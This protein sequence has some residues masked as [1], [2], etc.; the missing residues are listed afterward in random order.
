M[1]KTK[2]QILKE[3]KDKNRTFKETSSLGKIQDRIT[4]LES[5]M[6]EF[7]NAA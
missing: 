1:E 3:K 6:E 7:E 5:R 2:E 4:E